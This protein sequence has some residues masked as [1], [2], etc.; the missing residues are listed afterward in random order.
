VAR[1]KRDIC[2]PNITR[3]VKVARQT[4]ETD[5]KMPG[6]PR[7]AWCGKSVGRRNRIAAIIERATQRVGQLK[8]NFT[9]TT[10]L[11]IAKRTVRSTIERQTTKNWTL[12]SGRPPP[13][14]KKGNSPYGRER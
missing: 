12:W 11:E 7:I 8:K 3:R 13:K 9:K 5:R 1:R 4:K 14:R 6:R 2:R 10:K